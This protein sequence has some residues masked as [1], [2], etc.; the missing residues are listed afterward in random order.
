MLLPLVAGRKPVVGH[1]RSNFLTNKFHRTSCVPF[2]RG[3]VASNCT[4]PVS[5]SFSETYVGGLGCVR[6]FN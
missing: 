4:I 3:G 5:T 2:P 6:D 1:A